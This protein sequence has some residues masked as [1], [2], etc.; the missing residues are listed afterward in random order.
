MIGKSLG[1][2]EEKLLNPADWVITHSPC[3]N[4]VRLIGYDAMLSRWGT[5]N[6]LRDFSPHLT[7]IPIHFLEA[8]V[9]NLEFLDNENKWLVEDREVTH[10]FQTSVEKW[11]FRQVYRLKI[12]AYI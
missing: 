2:I 12:L 4:Q 9:K 1:N 6:V 7:A 10:L 3:H 5:G 11:Q 8:T